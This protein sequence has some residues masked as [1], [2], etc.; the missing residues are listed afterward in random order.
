MTIT[1]FNKLYD[2]YKYDFDHELMLTK[3]GT[4]YAQEYNQVQ[5][6]EEWF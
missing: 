2:H 6:S 3:T 1:L 4:T 5:E